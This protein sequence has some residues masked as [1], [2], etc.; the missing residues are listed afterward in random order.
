MAVEKLNKHKSQGIN[1][2]LAQSIKARGKTTVSEIHKLI[3]SIC[4]KEKLPEEWNESIVVPICKKGDKTDCSNFRR[5]SLCQLY[6]VQNVI[7]HRAF[8]F[9]SICKGNYWESSVWNAA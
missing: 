3:N 5:T 9:K 8:K 1:P 2:I 4:N 7:Q 6:T